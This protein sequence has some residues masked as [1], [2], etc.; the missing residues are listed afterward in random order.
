MSNDASKFD[1]FHAMADAVAQMGEEFP[2]PAGD[3]AAQVQQT[4]PP[5]PVE[6]VS[7]PA[8]DPTAQY[9]PD[10]DD[11]V[12]G[13]RIDIDA[14]LGIPKS[15]PAADPEPKAEVTEPAEPKPA[16]GHEPTAIEKRLS[17]MAAD[18]RAL[19]EQLDAVTRRLL[20]DDKPA[21]GAPATDDDGF[22]PS[23]DVQEYLR[24]Y[25]VVTKEDLADLQKAVEPLRQ[26]REDQE[27]ASFVAQHVDGFKA[28]HM[29]VL[30]AAIDKMSEQDRAP[31]R[32]VQGAALLA[33]SLVKRGALDLGTKTKS[34][35]APA[36]PNP[37]LARH[38]TEAAGSR[39]P[40][41]EAEEQLAWAKRINEM[42]DE[43][44]RAQLLRLP[45]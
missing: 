34:K 10:D 11:L 28:E 13:G 16:P 25:G 19:R 8:A 17:E 44:F 14:A 27:I 3:A 38:H 45:N 12:T 39:P 4:T 31:Y 29:P 20:G 6:A 22:E 37:L 24:K 30:Y 18:N 35:P 21:A 26:Q 36:E 5:A 43:E 42:S 23:P 15:K 2:A 7:V 9:A 32:G 1:E 40:M 41:G 33:A